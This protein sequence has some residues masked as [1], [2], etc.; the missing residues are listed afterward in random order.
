MH[1][2][3]PGSG[4]RDWSSPRDQNGI[5]FKREVDNFHPHRWNLRKSLPT[6]LACAVYALF[7]SIVWSAHQGTER[8]P[9]LE[10]RP[11]ERAAGPGPPGGIEDPAP[12][13]R[14]IFPAD[15]VLRR[16]IRPFHDPLRTLLGPA[17]PLSPSEEGERAVLLATAPTP[18]PATARP[19]RSAP[20][21]LLDFPPER[22]APQQTV[23]D[24]PP[25]SSPEVR[26][27]A[28]SPATRASEAGEAPAPEP[29]TEWPPEPAFKP[30]DATA[31]IA[32]PA[33]ASVPEL[34]DAEAA[35]DA[36]APE[37][38]RPALKPFSEPTDPGWRPA[39]RGSLI[40]RTAGDHERSSARSGPA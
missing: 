9:P 11:V 27:A 24:A 18:Q 39:V 2:V 17:A 21:A 14:S 33:A 25:G 1:G 13:A 22:P 29:A 5:L 12:H 30:L 23:N 19:Q 35:P 34:V 26:T 10:E 37:A 7:G 15:E 38:P 8:R 3:R 32:P 31:A 40:R 28:A 16:A 20:Q 6:L 4:G 36:A